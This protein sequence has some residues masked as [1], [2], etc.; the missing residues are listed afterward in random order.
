MTIISTEY[1]MDKLQWSAEISSPFTI[2]LE[3]TIITNATTTATTIS[4]ASILS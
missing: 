2:T 1:T 4:K 3:T